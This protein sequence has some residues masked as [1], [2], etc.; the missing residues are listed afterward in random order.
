[1]KLTTSLVLTT[2]L[3]AVALDAQTQP[4]FGMNDT[5]TNVSN[6]V[7][8]ASLSG[9]GYWAYQFT[10]ASVL[11]VRGGRVYTGNKFS[12]AFMSLEIWSHDTTTKL[13]KA[14][15]VGGTWKNAKPTAIGWYGTNFDK[16]QIL[17]KGTTYWLVWV[18][19]GFST[20]PIEPNGT[21][22]VSTAIR[23]GTGA[24]TSRTG[25]AALKCRLYCSLIDVQGVTVNGNPC[26]SRAGKLGSTFCQVVPSVGNA[27]FRI[28]GTGL[29]STARAYLALGLNKAWSSV[30][31]SPIAPGCFQHTD[32]VAFVV[33]QTGTGDVRSAAALGHV[34]Y[35]APIPNNSALKGIYVGAQ[36]GVVDAASTNL[37]PMVFTNGLKIV[38]Q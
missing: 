28:E 1:M 6:A 8:A 23:Y 2:V 12:D 38:I 15:L 21:T 5:N 34:N 26:A 25:Q 30:S 22:M 9:P 3:C 13:P 27:S 11:V 4:C 37:L 10:P 19:P 33:H 31:L 20:P 35:V 24:F 18:E 7:T 16:L 32:F 36:I 17:T 29:P 14:R